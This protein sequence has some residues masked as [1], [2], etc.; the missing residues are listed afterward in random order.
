MFATPSPTGRRE[1]IAGGWAHPGSFRDQEHGL[2]VAKVE[3][4]N[5]QREQLEL[6]EHLAVAMAA[7][8]EGER[9]NAELT[10][11]LEAA[12]GREAALRKSFISNATMAEQR[13]AELRAQLQRAMLQLEQARGLAAQCAQEEFATRG[14]LRDLDLRDILG[15]DTNP[16]R[17]PVAAHWC[18]LAPMHCVWRG[19]GVDSPLSKLVAAGVPVPGAQ[20]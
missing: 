8:D 16:G 19:A 17:S 10:A 11:R 2:R 4:E 18:D 15:L 5:A 7:L 13:E 1:R 3:A 20:M 14:A 12:E 9:K 6:S